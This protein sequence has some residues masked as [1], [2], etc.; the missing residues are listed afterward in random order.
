MLNFL[1]LLLFTFTAVTATVGLLHLQEWHD[2]D[3]WLL[4]LAD[5][6]QE[7]C[8]KVAKYFQLVKLSTE[9]LCSEKEFKKPFDVN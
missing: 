5:R 8:G 6:I 1:H 9:Q 4:P 3:H 2:Q 7:H